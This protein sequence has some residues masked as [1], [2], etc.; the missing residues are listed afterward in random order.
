[1]LA[2]TLKALGLLKGRGAAKSLV[3]LCH[4]ERLVGGLSVSL[5]ATP[6][7]VIGALAHALGGAATKL[8]LL[9]VRTTTPPVLEVQWREVHEQWEVDGLDALVHNLNDLFRDEPDVKVAV[10]LAESRLRKLEDGRYEYSPKK[11][12]A[13]ILTAEALV[14]RLVALSPPPNRHLTSFHGV[15]APNAKLRPLV[16]TPRAPPPA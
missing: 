16:V 14:K 6:D 12:V 8:K 5:R 11:G 2:T 3:R 1:M 15:Y 13:F 10:V 4:A 9:D 7:E